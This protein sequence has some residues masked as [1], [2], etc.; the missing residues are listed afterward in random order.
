[1]TKLWRNK[2][3]ILLMKNGALI[4]CDKCPC[5]E[6][7]DDDDEE[8]DPCDKQSATVA[9][10]AHNKDTGDG[11]ADLSSIN[12]GKARKKK[13]A[14]GSGQGTEYVAR[15]WVATTASGEEVGRGTVSND[16]TL[17]GAGT[18]SNNSKY[19]NAVNVSVISEDCDEY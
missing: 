12:A 9:L 18:V 11:L 4:T 15:R 5:E 6:D 17:N 10:P 1:M 2:D 3:G 8:E 7:D 14:D 16:G 13:S 19:D